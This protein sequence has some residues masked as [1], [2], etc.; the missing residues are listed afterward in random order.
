MAEMERR[1]SRTSLVGLGDM[2]L[3]AICFYAKIR[4]NLRRE[5]GTLPIY[6]EKP[7]HS[8]VTASKAHDGHKNA[9]L[10]FPESFNVCSMLH[11][12]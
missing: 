9:E 2:F 1:T 12:R 4:S 3:L 5:Q 10:F 7:I 11:V 8:R 6:T